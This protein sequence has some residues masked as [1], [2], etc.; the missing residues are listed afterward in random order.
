[1]LQPIQII[2]VLLLLFLFR[3]CW[4]RVSTFTPWRAAQVL[5]IHK[6]G[7]STDINKYSPISLTSVFRKTLEFCLQP[8]LHSHGPIL[9]PAQGGFRVHNSLCASDK[10]LSFCVSCL[11]AYRFFVVL[12]VITIFFLRS[13]LESLFLLIKYNKSHKSE[14][15]MCTKRNSVRY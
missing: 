7:S 1:M 6:K 13:T 10:F 2:L 4:T 15:E 14:R 3:L 9:D 8:I 5:P 12:P 11:P